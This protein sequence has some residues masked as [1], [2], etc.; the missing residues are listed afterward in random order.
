MKEKIGDRQH[1]FRYNGKT[2]KMTIAE[3]IDAAKKYVDSN[4][5]E[6]NFPELPCKVE[7]IPYGILLLYLL[8]SS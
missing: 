8:S 7:K 4:G 6:N 5:A 2:V 1:T 3:Y